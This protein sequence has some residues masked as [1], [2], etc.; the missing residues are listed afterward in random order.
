VVRDDGEAFDPLRLASRLR[1]AGRE[2]GS[3][4]MSELLGR[5]SHLLACAYERNEGLGQNEFRARLTRAPD[6]SI[7]DACTVST[8]GYCWDIDWAA[9]KL[10]GTE[11][12]SEVYY[13]AGQNPDL[14]SQWR[15][16]HFLLESLRKDQL[17]VV[18]NCDDRLGLAMLS[19]LS[20]PQLV[21]RLSS[22]APDGTG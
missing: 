4:V 7:V 9:S 16:V 10:A 2:A 3:L 8:T 18:L 13:D 1:A 5:H 11:G 14:S 20:H 6:R 17:L 21:I 19:E 15:Y 12:C 22:Q